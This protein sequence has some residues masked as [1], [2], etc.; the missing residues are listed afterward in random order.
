MLGDNYHW[1]DWEDEERGVAL[2]NFPYSDHSSKS[3]LVSFLSKLKWRQG[4]VPHL[5]GISQ[6]LT[7]EHVKATGLFKQRVCEDDDDDD[8]DLVEDKRLALTEENW[9]GPQ[10]ERENAI[11]EV[12]SPNVESCD[13]DG[14]MTMTP[15]D[16]RFIREFL[17]AP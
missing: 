9:E 15:S 16:L 2:K 11:S 8:D 6:P 10:E 1:A 4:A 13:D 3:E 7:K 17:M 14:V 5:V 12:S